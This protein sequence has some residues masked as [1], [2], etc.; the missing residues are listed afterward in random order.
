MRKQGRRTTV[1]KHN[2]LVGLDR[3][4]LLMIVI[5]G[6]VVALSV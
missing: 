1:V 4:V 6:I 3:L 2:S 5:M